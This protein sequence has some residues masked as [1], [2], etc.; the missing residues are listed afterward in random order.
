MVTDI[1]P[2]PEAALL[3]AQTLVVTDAVMCNALGPYCLQSGAAWKYL[4]DAAVPPA[5]LWGFSEL[6]KPSSPALATSLSFMAYAVAS[7]WSAGLVYELFCHISA[8]VSGAISGY[9]PREWT[10]ADGLASLLLVWFTRF[11]GVPLV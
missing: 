10:G 8:F 1:P 3:P 11:K 2:P 6:A 7:G 4:V 9:R 5:V